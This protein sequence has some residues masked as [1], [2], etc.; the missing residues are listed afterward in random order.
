MEY[1]NNKLANVLALLNDVKSGDTLN[2]SA[3]MLLFPAVVIGSNTTDQIIKIVLGSE[4]IAGEK[5]LVTDQDVQRE[6]HTALS[7][8]G[9]SDDS[10]YPNRHYVGTELH[11]KHISDLESELQSLLSK[12]SKITKF[13][14]EKGHPFYPVFWDFSFNIEVSGKAY[15]FIGSCSD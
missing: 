2:Y 3:E 8:L 6:L 1:F 10:S 4:A 5:S 13:Y 7:Y 15:L 9:D 12:A 11:K 14:L